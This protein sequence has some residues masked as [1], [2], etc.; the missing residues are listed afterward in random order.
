V[1]L[2]IELC[3]ASIII[4]GL[5]AL[6]F[7]PTS[8][9]WLAVGP[10]IAAAALRPLLIGRPIAPDLRAYGALSVPCLVLAIARP[11]EGSSGLGLNLPFHVALFLSAAA[12]LRL[13]TPDDPQRLPQILFGASSALATAGAD[14]PRERYVWLVLLFAVP[15]I[16]IARAALGTRRLEGRPRP[17]YLGVAVAFAFAGALTFGLG[18][19]VEAIWEDVSR[20][21]MKGLQSAPLSEAGGFSGQARLGNIVGLQKDGGRTVA[22]RVLSARP[23]GYLRARTFTTYEDGAWKAAARAVEKRLA[24]GPRGYPRFAFPG[25]RAGPEPDLSIH[26]AS[27]YGAHFF[28][29][30][31]AAALEPPG[32]TIAVMEPGLAVEAHGRSSSA[33]Y[34]VF[35]DPSPLG[36]D[37]AD[38]LAL[39]NDPAVIA[40]L[41]GTIA[42]LGLR[43]RPTTAEACRALDL[44]FAARYRYRIGVLFRPGA[45][46]IVRF[47]EEIDH[48]HCELFATSGV[49]LLRRMGIPARYVTGF[50]CLERVGPDL[51]L[52]REKYG[53]AWVEALDEHDGWTTV[54]L[55]PASGVPTADPVDTVE[56]WL[57]RLR[58]A[59]ERFAGAFL[60]SG[61]LAAI[62]TL[63]ALGKE[64]L[65]EEWW[66]AALPVAPFVAWGLRRLARRRARPVAVARRLAPELERDR[67]RLL[68]LERSLARAGFARA[69]SETLH[70]WA[71]RLDASGGHADATAFIRAYAERRY[72][73]TT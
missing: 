69:D 67:A 46:P 55:T 52:A 29:P 42:K 59:W 16:I 19:F 43:P 18:R 4:I 28:L 10:L 57:E 63:L 70:E 60:R 23:P 30:L 12:T 13:Y 26:P 61:V 20:V 56:S 48:G 51:W 15:S 1:K 24:P 53:H 45:D 65:V 8:S 49:L 22:L 47:L 44:W 38:A 2:L 5:V 58:A 32:D 11:V 17:T 40:A 35:L 3:A 66:H 39:P 41:D 64:W 33:G 50:V 36:G 54:E 34:D 7:A 25:R 68:A 27:R 14:A 6:G 21:F 73:G 37:G 62:G 9:E 72:A 31:G 71:A